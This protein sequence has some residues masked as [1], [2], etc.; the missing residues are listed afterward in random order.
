MRSIRLA[1][2]ALLCSPALLAA[3]QPSDVAAVHRDGQTFITW[4]E[5]GAPGYRIYRSAEAMASIAD[6]EAIAELG[7]D[8]SADP[9][10]AARKYPLAKFTKVPDYGKRYVIEDNPDADPGKMLGVDTGLYVH[11]PDE[12]GTAHYAVV[13]LD[14]EGAPVS[15]ISEA[16][17]SGS[18]DEQPGAVPG[19]VL[20]QK[21]EIT[22]KDGTVQGTRRYYIHW[23]D[24]DD[25]APGPT[26]G[27]AYIFSVF[28]PNEPRGMVLKLHGYS[29]S[30]GPAGAMRDMV[31][32]VVGDPAQ[33]WFYGYRDESGERV[34]DYTMR[35]ML[36]TVEGTLRELAEEGIEVDRNKIYSF[37]GS[38]GGTG[39]N[40][41]AAWHGD[42]FAAVISSLGAVD[43]SRNG[44]WTGVAEKRLWGPRAENLP[45]QDGEPV[46][47]RLNLIA[48]HK[49]HPEVETAFILD[50]HATNDG[51][52]P[53]AAIPEYYDAL[54][55][56]RR[57]FAAIWGTWG[58]SGM[59]EPR[60]PN[61]RW[62]GT[63]QFNK[64]ESVPAL[65]NAS[66]NDDPRQT[67]KRQINTKLEWS[68]R[69]NDFDGKSSEDD[70]VDEADRWAICIR[71]KA[72]DQ[73][74]DVTPR[75][76]QNF[77][78]EPGASYRW[79]NYDMSDP[80]NPTKLAEGAVTADEHGLVT[81][82]QMAVGQ[83]GWGN[84]L[85]ISSK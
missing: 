72:G 1:T 31:N 62:W 69:E 79:V 80:G 4:S 64:D 67:R 32:V 10:E 70:I 38:M 50:G 20:L 59:H 2:F 61:H 55:E 3:A 58:H 37:G 53:Y 44:K 33:S 39:S 49:A 85:V 21:Q 12:A 15:A 8:S 36:L 22:G 17:Q 23:M 9:V 83:Q 30:Y 63:F 66:S 5:S 60:F 75:R 56:A 82:R 71:S 54:Q 73:T 84:R 76:C 42:V 34:G 47:D 45:T 29:G 7:D 6:G 14:A 65:G 40:F 48:W 52:I 19:L 16:N 77:A 78:P 81:V 46:W 41:L 13:A 35:R 26:G 43:H 57:P 68:A 25:W 11:S 74:V 51:S 18:V 24:A 28:V 27:P